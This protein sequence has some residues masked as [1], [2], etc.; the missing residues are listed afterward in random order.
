MFST[1]KEETKKEKN[2]QL[3]REEMALNLVQFKA[4]R[5]KSQRQAAEELDIPRTTIQH[6]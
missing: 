6:C 4:I 1:T 5:S 3:D 2:R